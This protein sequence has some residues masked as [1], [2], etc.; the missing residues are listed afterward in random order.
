M[1]AKLNITA[2][3]LQ[4]ASDT[5]QQYGSQ[6]CESA[7]QCARVNAAACQCLTGMIIMPCSI[8]MLAYM[9]P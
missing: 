7:M 5:R 1:R 6:E 3:S 9:Q 8:S 2:I 4:L